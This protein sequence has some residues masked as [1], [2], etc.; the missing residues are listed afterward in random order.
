MIT[1]QEVIAAFTQA[2][3]IALRMVP[4]GI[5]RQAADFVRHGFNLAEL[6]LVVAWTKRQIRLG[7]S[8]FTE[9]SYTWRRLFGE[10]G[11]PDEFQAFQERLGL[12]QSELRRG[13]KPKLAA[14]QAPATAAPPPTAPQEKEAD[15]EATLKIAEDFWRKMGRAPVRPQGNGV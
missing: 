14:A 9:A 2:T 11:S 5:Q 8:G 7:K 15:R 1:P 12:A 3:G 6:E 13:W 10:H 4:H